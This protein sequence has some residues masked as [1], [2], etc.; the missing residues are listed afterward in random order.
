M[1]ESMATL[2]IVD[3]D[4][5][6]LDS[7]AMGFAR[8]P[9]RL[10]TAPGGAE[11]LDV[12][13]AEPVDVVLTDLKMPGVD[14]LEV[15]RAAAA[16]PSAP[17][18]IVVTAFGTIETAV[19]AMRRGAFDYITKPVNLLELRGKIEK[20]L[21]VRALRVKPAGAQGVR[22]DAGIPEDVRAA[23]AEQGASGSGVDA[24]ASGRGHK[25][26]GAFH[27]DGLMSGSPR[28]RQVFEQVRLVAKSKASV[29]VEGESGTG[30]ELIARAIHRNSPRAAGPFVAIHCAAFADTLLESELF[31]YEKGAFTGAADRR[32]G[33]FESAH[34]GTVFLD[35]IGEISAATQVK[36]LRVLEEREITRVGSSRPLT[37]DIRLVAATNKDLAKEVKEGRFREDLFYRLNVVRLHLPPLRERVEDIRPLVLYFLKEIARENQ[38]PPLALTSE[39]MAVLERH[40]WYGNIRELHNV[41]EQIVVF[42]TGEVVDVDGLP[43]SLKLTQIAPGGQAAPYIAA[44]PPPQTGVPGLPGTGES[45]SL[46]EVEKRHILEVL[47][48]EHGN[49]T[50]A[51][52]R[53]GISRRTMQRK[54]KE[55]GLSEE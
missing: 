6:N 51:A 4:R 34:G 50:R 38:C 49:R 35:E 26:G 37:I 28:M 33:H 43:A 1:T 24:P 25:S 42:S 19:E 13:R 45:L 17:V 8:Q 44:A 53:L 39:A 54:L 3:D 47:D 27:F 12:L 46:A 21:K 10:I 40:P 11:A 14:G 20:A 48:Q 7:Y 41:V 36:L 31:G 16:L 30:K 22:A 15:V 29:L 52:I 32:V 5:A 23:L 18:C 2:L 9:Y 55:L